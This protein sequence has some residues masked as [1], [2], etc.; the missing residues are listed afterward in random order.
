MNEAQ[1]RLELIDPALEV[2]GW[3]EK[4]ASIAVEQ[5]APGRVGTK[6]RERRADYVLMWKNRRALFVK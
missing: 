5:I 4:P 6:G 3:R 2:A 1:T